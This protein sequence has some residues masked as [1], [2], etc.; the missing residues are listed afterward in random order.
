MNGPSADGAAGGD[1]LDGGDVEAPQPDEVE[2]GQY[3][4]SPNPGGLAPQDWGVG[5]PSDEP[6]PTDLVDPREPLRVAETAPPYL[7]AEPGTVDGL[8]TREALYPALPSSAPTP[9]SVQTPAV[10]P[11]PTA[12]RLL[13][14]LLSLDLSNLTPLQ[15]LIRLHQLQETARGSVPWQAWLADLAG[16][17][18]TAPRPDVASRPSAN[19]R[20][21]RP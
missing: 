13:G 3:P 12:A 8:A 9:A 7:V 1:W 15:A 16:G 2:R 14:E 4:R 5:G 19:G 18:G 10:P 6:E 21:G 17:D 20:A 11:S